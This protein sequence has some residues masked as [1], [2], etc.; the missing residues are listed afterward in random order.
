MGYVLLGFAALNVVSVSGA[1]ANMVAHGVMSALFFAMIGFIYEKTHL[2]TVDDLKGLAC[3]MPRLATGFMLAGMASLGL[4]GLIGFVPEFTIFV[5]A[6]AEFPILAVLAI[7]GGH[8]V[9]RVPR[10][11]RRGACAARAL[12]RRSRGLRRVP[13]SPPGADFDGDG[14]FAANA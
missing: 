9:R 13:A 6:F 5:G 11:A 2:R 14:A 7:P 1:V 12:G 8:E 10:H 3:Q 4:P